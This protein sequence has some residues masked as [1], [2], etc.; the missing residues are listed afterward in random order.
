MSTTNAELWDIGRVTGAFDVDIEFTVTSHE[1][2]H[3]LVD[4]VNAIDGVLEN[5]TAFLLQYVRN[6]YD[7]GTDR[8]AA[9]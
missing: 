8:K 3:V 4:R 5:E 7:W 1:K 9:D 6:R 2:L